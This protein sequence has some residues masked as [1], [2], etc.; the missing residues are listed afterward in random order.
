MAILLVLLKLK[1]QHVFD[2]FFSN[3][4]YFLAKCQ[5]QVVSASELESLGKIILTWTP[6]PSTTIN[7]FYLGETMTSEHRRTSHW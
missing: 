3:Q 4:D 1:S 6:S 7:T 5:T 2:M